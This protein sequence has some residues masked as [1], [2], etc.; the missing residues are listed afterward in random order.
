MKRQNYKMSDSD[1]WIVV[2]FFDRLSIV[3]NIRCGK[4]IRYSKIN[5]MGI[6]I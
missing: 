6:A 2:F 4:V 5:P 3:H 1:G